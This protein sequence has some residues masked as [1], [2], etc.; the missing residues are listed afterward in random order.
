MKD[1]IDIYK[2]CSLLSILGQKMYGQKYWISDRF[3]FWINFP[4]IFDNSVQF[5]SLLIV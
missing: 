5:L 4:D 3:D 2:I 1:D